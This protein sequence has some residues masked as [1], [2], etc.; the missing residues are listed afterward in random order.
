MFHQHGDKNCKECRGKLIIDYTHAST[1]CSNCGLEVRNRMRIDGNKYRDA[2]HA[3]GIKRSEQ[4]GLATYIGTFC[5]DRTPKDGDMQR[6]RNK[7]KRHRNYIHKMHQ[8]IA[9]DYHTE[10]YLYMIY[11]QIE[12]ISFRLQLVERLINCAKRYAKEYHQQHNKPVKKVKSIA[13]ACVCFS[14]R[15][16]NCPRSLKE[17]VSTGIVSMRDLVKHLKVLTP[18]LR[19]KKKMVDPCML[20]NRH[21]SQFRFTFQQKRKAKE[22]ATLIQDMNILGGRSPHS[23]VAVVLYIVCSMYEMSFSL[24]DVSEQ[25]DIAVNTSGHCLD[26]VCCKAKDRILEIFDSKDRFKQLCKSIKVNDSI[27]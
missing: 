5:H 23:I 1:V 20:M 17:I 24:K 3:C 27:K 26:I 15:L 2:E 22:L 8:R 10:R 19:I 6:K 12:E 18:I 11:A 4:I 21:M 16:C 13:A 14:C 9:M 7:N 25:V